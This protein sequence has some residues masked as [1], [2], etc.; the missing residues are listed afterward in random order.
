[1]LFSFFL[2]MKTYQSV[3]EEKCKFFNRVAFVSKIVGINDTNQEEKVFDNLG[4]VG[5]QLG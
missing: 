1:M 4:W 3:E 2:K 5:L